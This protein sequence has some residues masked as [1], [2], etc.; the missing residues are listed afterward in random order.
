MVVRESPTDLIVRPML[1]LSFRGVNRARAHPTSE[2]VT[3]NFTPGKLNQLQVELKE[4]SVGPL[5]FG[6]EGTCGIEKR[7]LELLEE[8]FHPFG[9][10][11][12]ELK[13]K[14]RE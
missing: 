10:P 7:L 4:H 6:F 2:R 12:L 3:D 9:Y 5:R 14:E 11:N 8:A 1:S 13:A